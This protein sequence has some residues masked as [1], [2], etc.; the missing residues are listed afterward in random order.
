MTH[1]IKHLGSIATQAWGWCPPLVSSMQAGFGCVRDT[2]TE[3]NHFGVSPKTEAPVCWLGSGNS[4]VPEAAV[5]QSESTRSDLLAF[6][7]WLPFL[8]SPRSDHL[9]FQPSCSKP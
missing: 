6:H 8:T 3:G 2:K 4:E 7:V 1:D 5:S 9:L